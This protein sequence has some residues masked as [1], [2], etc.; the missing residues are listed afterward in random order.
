MHHPL[1]AHKSCRMIDFCILTREDA[2]T[3][4]K[5]DL[6]ELQNQLLA[7]LEKNSVFQHSLSEIKV[8]RTNGQDYSK[9]K[10]QCQL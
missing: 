3:E 6:L 8:Y 2:G 4:G 10:F 5:K 9:Q 1:Y 7:R